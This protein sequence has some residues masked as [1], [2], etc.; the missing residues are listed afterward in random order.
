MLI[1]FHAH[2]RSSDGADS[3]LEMAKEAKC[4][5]HSA[6]CIT[7]HDFMMSWYA[8]REILRILRAER[9]LPLPVI[10][11]SE[12]STPWGEI[13]LFGKQALKNYFGGKHHE[14][15]LEL[16]AMRNDIREEASQ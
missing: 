11:G 2:T 7:D 4:L 15:F 12:V 10:L 16:A 13:C 9:M 5:G 1:N 14:K 3:I 6:L 8:G